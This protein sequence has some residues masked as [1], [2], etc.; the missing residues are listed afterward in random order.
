MQAFTGTDAFDPSSLAGEFVIA[1][2][3]M[4]RDLLLPALLRQ[5][6]SV[7]P[8][9][10]LRVIPSH[11]PTPEML[12]EERC[13]LIITPRP[14]LIGDVLQRRLFDDRY[15]CYFDAAVRS[16]PATLEEYLAAEHV[17]VAYESRGPLEIDRI[18]TEQGLQRTFA[19][20][21]PNF[22]GISSFLR[23]SA[24][25]ATLPSMLGADLLRGFDQAAPPM[26]CP[27]M[28]M[29]MVWHQRDHLDAAHRWLR[30]QL[31]VLTES[32]REPQ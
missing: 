16:A 30:E 11:V 5:L 4:Q 1:A 12:R 27:T 29:Y 15:V 31:L 6:R 2:N 19:A 18:L 17:T 10:T 3:D 9:V 22:S 21:V 20:V 13:Q 7:A 8:R 14:P 23:G 24:Y 26:A 32:I 25:L 28:P